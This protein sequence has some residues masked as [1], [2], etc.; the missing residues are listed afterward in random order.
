MTFCEDSTPLADHPTLRC[1]PAAKKTDRPGCK[2]EPSGKIL[3]KRGIPCADYCTL[4][5]GS[6]YIDNGCRRK[7]VIISLLAV[8]ARNLL[9]FCGLFM[10]VR[11]PPCFRIIALHHHHEN[12][13]I[14]SRIRCP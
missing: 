8:H 12:Q 4:R 5:S 11:L 1:T 9:A 7:S 10:A 13:H 3:R 2:I 14:P 6:A